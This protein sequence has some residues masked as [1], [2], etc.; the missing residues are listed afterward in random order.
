VRVDG[1]IEMTLAEV[2]AAAAGK[3]PAPKKPVRKSTRK[4]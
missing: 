2:P 4:R 1:I 3:K